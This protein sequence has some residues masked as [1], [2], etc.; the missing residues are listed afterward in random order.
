[1]PRGVDERPDAGTPRYQDVLIKK[2][3]K[4]YKALSSQQEKTE[5]IDELSWMASD[6]VNPQV[7]AMEPDVVLDPAT[8]TPSRLKP[9]AMPDSQ[10]LGIV[11]TRLLTAA[12]VAQ[13]LNKSCAMWWQLHSPTMY[14]PCSSPV[15]SL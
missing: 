8:S 5:L 3:W 6:D 14:S 15:A 11:T 2:C 13:R 1:M 9:R 4:H 12:S 7:D 10:L